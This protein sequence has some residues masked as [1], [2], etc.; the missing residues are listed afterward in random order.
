M[1][2]TQSKPRAEIEP[3]ILQVIRE[4]KIA[5]ALK[6]IRGHLTLGHP[7]PQKSA[8]EWDSLVAFQMER[9]KSE[10][11]EPEI[12]VEAL[13]KAAAYVLE[14]MEQYDG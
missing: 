7:R 14:A 3:Y 10:R 11:F 5:N 13:A 8:S 4:E 6:R 12:K 9:F 1:S 2:T